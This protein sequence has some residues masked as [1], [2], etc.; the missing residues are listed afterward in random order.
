MV[1]LAQELSR[2]KAQA[3]DWAGWADRTGP[4]DHSE[5]GSR[6]GKTQLTVGVPLAT[7]WSGDERPFDEMTPR[8]ISRHRALRLY[9][10]RKKRKPLIFA[11]LPRTM[12][13]IR[14]SG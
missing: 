12:Q 6:D 7:G 11:S 3:S 13:E 9:R 4:T 14:A 2:A 8:Y 1:R 10:R 5:N